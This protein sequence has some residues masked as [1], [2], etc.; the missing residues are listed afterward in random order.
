MLVLQSYRYAMHRAKPLE[1]RFRRFAGARRW[2]WNKALALQFDA[3]SRGEK[4]PRYV[5][6]ANRLPRWKLEH[7]WLK[8]IHSQ[9]LQ[10]AL[11][12]LDRAWAKRFKDLSAVKR[13]E[14]RPMDAAGEPSFRRYGIG[15][16]FRYP[17]PKPEH[18]D[19]ANG[20]VFLPKIGWARYRNSRRP[21]GQP[22]QI[23]VSLDAGRWVVS[24]TSEVERQ[25][26]ALPCAGEVIGADRGVTDTLALSNGHRVAPL[27][28][29]KR[30]AYRLK[31][32]QRA[33]ARKIEAQK[34]AMGLDPKAPF[35]KGVRPG[36]SNRQRRAEQRVARC[37]RHI[38][39][40]R[41]DWLHKETTQIAN[42]AAVVVL[43]DLNIR[44][45]TASA[46]GCAEAPGRNVRQ[47]AGLNRAILDQGW[48]ALEALLRY[49]LGWR[50]GEVI[51]VSPAYTSQ[52]CSCCGHVDAASRNGKH[53]LCTACGHAE[54]A[55]INA[56]KNILAA[57]LA[58]L[59]GRTAAR[60]DVED[61]VQP[62][63]PMKRQPASAKG[64]AACNP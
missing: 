52:K 10:Q 32:Y 13:G 9:V 45:M 48:H 14:M 12:D 27:N 17:Q 6:L 37:H 15:D 54:D 26:G 35:P 7:P 39:N 63:R 43:E 38:A 4:A 3:R 50:G 61:A 40:Q 41:R 19:A 28:A 55:D 49:K 30:S 56:A 16:S 44:N 58:V 11:K 8:E 25:A 20:R 29:L 60:M 31:R 36:K 24:I 53:Y 42:R 64:G 57:G 62:S 21:E 23:T 5:D 59:A 1:A 34:R 18:V 46:K 51:K 2:V 47:K 33:V 22:K